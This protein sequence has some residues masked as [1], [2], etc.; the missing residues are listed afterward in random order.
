[1]CHSHFRATISELRELSEL[2]YFTWRENNLYAVD[3]LG[4]IIDVHSHLALSFVKKGTVDLEK[5]TA[6]VRT[7]L[8]KTTPIN[9]HRYMNTN[10]PK[11]E[12]RN[13]KK[14]M[15][16]RSLTKKG[17]RQTHT[18]PN[19][20][21]EMTMLGIK[22]SI[23]LAIDTPTLSWNT[24]DYLSIGEKHKN[25]PVGCS[26]HPSRPNATNELRKWAAAGAVC[27]KMHP[28]VQNMRPD[29]PRAMELYE[30]C[31]ELGIPVI[32]HC[33]PVG[34]VSKAADERC[35]LKHYWRAVHSFPDTTF[36]LGHAGA[37]Q[38][39]LAIELVNHY[40]NVYM[41]VSCQGLEGIEQI[42]KRCSS[43]KVMHGSDWPFYHQAVSVAKVLI[44]SEGN[45]ELRQRVL[46]DNA[47]R[48]FQLN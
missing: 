16:I 39:D 38:Y 10:I 25:L 44:A 19:L 13:M 17:M 36:V 5:K 27:M 21:S 31:G 42:F 34:I 20:V 45:G 6:D 24:S 18:A 37:L 29:D 26:V 22:K 1:M 43:E 4:P 3:D 30:V 33:G 12:M 8:P 46:H 7:Y 11:A 2:P 40:D 9:L 23:I 15:S 48:V 41:E 47:Q 14:D 28:A 35:Q 32:W